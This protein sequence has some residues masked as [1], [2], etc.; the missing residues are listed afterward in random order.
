[1]ST[2]FNSTWIELQETN[3][4]FMYAGGLWIHLMAPLQGITRSQSVQSVYGVRKTNNYEGIQ[5]KD[6]GTLPSNHLLHTAFSEP[7]LG[8]YGHLSARKPAVRV[9]TP[10]RLNSTLKSTVEVCTQT[11]FC[12]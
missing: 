6:E 3:I 8:F 4:P 11:K 7:L 10:N 2:E 5:G 9:Q 12:D 1:M